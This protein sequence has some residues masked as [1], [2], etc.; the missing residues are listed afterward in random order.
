MKCRT[1]HYNVLALA[2]VFAFSAH[3]APPARAMWAWDSK[4]STELLRFARENNV[5]RLFL[6]YSG[7]AD[8]GSVRQFLRSA[9]S[10]GLRV[11]ALDGWPEAALEVN[12]A[13]VL[14]EA[15]AILH[16]NA[17]NPLAE[18]WAGFHLDVEPYLLA[19]WETAS[20]P[21][22]RR[23][24][25]ELNRKVAAVLKE[26][27]AEFGLDVPFWLDSGLTEDL[28][29]LANHIA[30]MDYRNQAAGRDGII[31]LGKG[32]VDAAGRKGVAAFL[33]VETGPADDERMVLVRRFEATAWEN[34]TMEQ[35]P[36]LGVSRLQGFRINVA[37][38]AGAYYVGLA[39]SDDP[40]RDPALPEASAKLATSMP[41]TKDCRRL[42]EKARKDFAGR[43]EFTNFQA[44]QPERLCGFEVKSRGL[45]KTTFAGSAASDM[46]EQLGLV[47][48]TFQGHP[49]FAGVA[50]HHYGTWQKMAAPAGR[51]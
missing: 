31:A 4:G 6:Q 19:G 21:R 40:S 17:K 48:T 1:L 32:L 5:S 29:G 51:E 26:G 35:L 50:I 45:L 28:L 33:G 41:G 10:Q 15:R 37:K 24:F 44:F 30:V 25:V 27:G 16:F 49:G 7:S 46:E 13:A 36:W 8:E 2:L 14:E 23:E 42:M 34:L 39:K 47:E 9:T 12:H 43:R 3:G 20:G 38:V 18:R 22:I 11:Y